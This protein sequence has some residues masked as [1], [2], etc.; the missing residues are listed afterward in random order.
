MYI[1][2]ELIQYLYN[3]IQFLSNLSKIIQSHKTVDITFI[4]V[5]IISCFVASK[6]KKIQKNHKNN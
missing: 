1:L 3:L 4:D 5:D 2:K 6:G